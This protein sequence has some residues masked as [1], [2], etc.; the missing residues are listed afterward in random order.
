LPLLEDQHCLRGLA[1]LIQLIRNGQQRPMPSFA[2]IVPG[3]AH[4]QTI[5]GY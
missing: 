4:A 3:G 1:T 5:G 2:V